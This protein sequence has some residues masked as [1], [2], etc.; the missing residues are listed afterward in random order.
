MSLDTINIYTDGSF[1][2]T[3]SGAI[4]GYGIYFPNNEIKSIASAFT[5]QPITN[6]RAELYAIYRAIRIVKKKYTFNQM[7]IWTDSQYAQKSLTQ[8]IGKWKN[9]NWLNASKKPVENQDILKDI[10]RLLDM[11][12]GK[13]FIRWIPAHTGKTDPHSICNNIADMLANRGA[14]KYKKNI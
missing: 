8:W 6:N 11:F 5:I 9:N 3:A 4:A 2:K 10:D 7:Y 12:Q 1:K 14:E 13:I